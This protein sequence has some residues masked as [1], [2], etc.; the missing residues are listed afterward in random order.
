MRP[1]RMAN[2]E[3]YA[4][5]RGSETAGVARTEKRGSGR[6]RCTKVK[7]SLGDVCDLSA[8]GAR[9]SCRK[10]TLHSNDSNVIVL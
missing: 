6:L 5:G 4:G 1:Q 7:C 10:N 8:T 3:K 2:T 9:L